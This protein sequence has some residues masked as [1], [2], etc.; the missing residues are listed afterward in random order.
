MLCSIM[1]IW[2]MFFDK[3][4]FIIKDWAEW[5]HVEE[6]SGAA[7][8]S[9]AEEGLRGSVQN[10]PVEQKN[11]RKPEEAARSVQTDAAETLRI[12]DAINISCLSSDFIFFICLC[13]KKL[14]RIHLTVNELVK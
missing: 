5:K 2:V 8:K 10:I 3:E 9:T 12:Q 6:K 4:I 7:T 14:V 1:Q 11:R 13:W